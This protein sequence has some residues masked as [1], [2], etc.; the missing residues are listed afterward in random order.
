MAMIGKLRAKELE[1]ACAELGVTGHWYLGG[2]GR[3]RDSTPK[4]CD[5][6]RAFC[7]ADLDEAADE[8]AILIRKVQPQV[9]VTYDANGLDGHPDRTQAHQV[10]W[11]A[12]QQ[13]C[14]PSRTKF[15]AVTMP[16][17]VLADAINAAQQSM[18]IS[19]FNYRIQNIDDADWS[20]VCDELAPAFAAV[21]GLVRKIWIHGEG[22]TRGGLYMWEDK[23]A[24]KA[25]LDSDLGKAFGSHPNIVDL[26]TR[27]YTLDE[28]PTRVTRGPTRSVPERFLRFGVPDDQVSTEIRAD[29][30]LEAKLAAL[31]AHTT[32]IVV[33][34]PFFEAAGLV[35]MRALGTE[36]YT[37]LSH[38]GGVTTGSR[39]EGRKDDLFRGSSGLAQSPGRPVSDLAATGHGEQIPDVF[40]HTRDDVLNMLDGLL[41]GRATPWDEFYAA[42]AGRFLVEWPDENLAAWF[43]D[44]LL[45]PGRVL[46]LGCGHGRNA[47]Y[48][49]SLGCSVDAIDSSEQ[50]IRKA[51]KR[52]ERAGAVVNFR[53]CSIFDPEL[54]E[55]SYDLVYDH[56]CFHHLPPHRRPDYVDLVRRVLKPGGSFGLVCF[57][58]EAGSG[59]TD[60]QVYERRSLGKGLGYSEDR[61][62]ALWDTRPFFLRALRQM[63]KT[64]ELGPFYGENYLWALLATKEQIP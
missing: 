52:A 2:P 13:A 62:R 23:A 4:G 22:D 30:C 55:E 56:G 45:T 7:N 16:R 33:D 15:Y 48:L 1:A 51:A 9:M 5:D 21:P 26:T 31:K 17:L 64:D 27:D 20:L 11:R 18:H 29:S 61:L 39:G 34:G 43:G 36:Y 37:L 3:W 58:S 8:L 41:A 49:A 38:P 63:T 32:Q 53:C 24:Y 47:T 25:F 42:S 28:G 50:A 19:V 12:Y 10:A 59:Y 44:G 40:I 54:T 6:P 14:D 60:Q 46:E 35:R 57:G